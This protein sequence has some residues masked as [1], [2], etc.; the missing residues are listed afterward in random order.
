MVSII[1]LCPSVSVHIGSIAACV[2]TNGCSTWICTIA[3]ICR[4]SG[5]TAAIAAIIV[6]LCYG[7]H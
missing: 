7:N 1:T 5:T 6:G 3:T 4:S 2:A